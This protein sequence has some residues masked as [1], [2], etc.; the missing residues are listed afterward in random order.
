MKYRVEV[1]GTVYVESESLEEAESLVIAN[2][3]LILTD[4]DLEVEAF[5]FEEG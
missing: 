1:V 2:P 5:A 3:E 4:D